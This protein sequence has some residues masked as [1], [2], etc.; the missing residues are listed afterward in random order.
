MRLPNGGDTPA[1]RQGRTSFGI[2]YS[3]WTLHHLKL[4]WKAKLKELNK[5]C[6][7]SGAVIVCFSTEKGS[8][9]RLEALTKEKELALR[10]KFTLGVAEFLKSLNGNSGIKKVQLPF[11]FKNA[12]WAFEVLSNTFLPKPLT[13][14]Q[15]LACKKFLKKHS[16]KKGCFL[17]EECVFVYSFK[18]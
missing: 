1:F 16:S 4:D 2:V 18:K 9:P 15:E 7:K 10:K 5:A 14:K 6:R 12:N 17:S 11:Y 13:A 8:I 3:L